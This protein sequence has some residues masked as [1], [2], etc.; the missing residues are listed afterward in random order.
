MGIIKL[1]EA[2]YPQLDT[3][4]RDQTIFI[5]P[6]GMLEQHGPHLP[7]GSDSI[8]SEARAQVTSEALNARRPNLNVVIFPLIPL[9]VHPVELLNPSFKHVGS[10]WIRHTTLRDILVDVGLSIANYNFN[11]IAIESGHASPMH[12]MAIDVASKYVSRKRNVKMF[13]VNPLVGPIDVTEINS[14]LKE[15]IDQAELDK[16]KFDFHAGIWETSRILYL[17][18]ELV[19]EGYVK[20]KSTLLEKIE[21]IYRRAKDKDWK[22]FLGTPKL[23]RKDFGEASLKIYGERAAEV[24][25]KILDGAEIPEVERWFQKISVNDQKVLDELLYELERR[26][27][28]DLNLWIEE[29]GILKRYLGDLQN[30]GSH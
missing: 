28:E 20:L 22:G 4:E 6:V 9:G 8:Q 14:M 15:P 12:M 21:D 30:E 27:E 18:P 25:L 17:R 2:R 10:F 29:S 7:V 23:G 13:H 24:I 26:L 1:E 5:V 3:L 19:D 16:A 11:F